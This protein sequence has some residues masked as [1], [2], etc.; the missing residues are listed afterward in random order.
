MKNAQKKHNLYK[1]YGYAFIFYNKNTIKVVRLIGKRLFLLFVQKENKR[2][3]E[4]QIPDNPKHV[5]EKAKQIAAEHACRDI[6]GMRKRQ[7]LHSRRKR[8][9]TLNRHKYTAEH[10][11]TRNDNR[12]DRPC[13]FFIFGEHAAKYTEGDIK[14]S[15]RE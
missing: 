15:R 1:K 11:G 13:L 7:K 12:P 3:N 14:E 5:R 9:H 8:A 2:P 6:D 4:Q 10:G